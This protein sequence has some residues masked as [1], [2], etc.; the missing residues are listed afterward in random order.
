MAFVRRV[1][2]RVVFMAEGRVVEEGSPDQVFERP[3][4]LRAQEFVDRILGH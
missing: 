4:T 2:T 3:R 1:S